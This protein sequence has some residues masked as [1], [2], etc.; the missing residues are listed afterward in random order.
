MAFVV[1]SIMEPML[2]L[3]V[4]KAPVRNIA[5]VRA[6]KDMR[7]RETRL[8]A[9]LMDQ[10]ARDV[11]RLRCARFSSIVRFAPIPYVITSQEC[12]HSMSNQQGVGP[13]SLTRALLMLVNAQ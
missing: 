13:R 3:Y 6:S 1:R 4:S 11:N 10:G 5:G 2:W 7:R 9:N 8:N 12:G